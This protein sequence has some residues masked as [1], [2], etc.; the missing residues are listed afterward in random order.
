MRRKR[1]VD[2]YSEFVEECRKMLHC[3]KLLAIP[4]APIFLVLG[5]PQSVED[6][7]EQLYD[8]NKGCSPIL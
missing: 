5:P 7:N 6:G 2:V 1:R 3:G 4:E 8:L